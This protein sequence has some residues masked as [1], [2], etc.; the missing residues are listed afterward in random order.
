MSIFVTGI[1]RK[2]KIFSNLPFD[3]RGKWQILDFNF[4]Q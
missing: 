2:R 3:R 1:L 4:I